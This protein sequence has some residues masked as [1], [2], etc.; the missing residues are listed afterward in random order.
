[1]VD[2]YRIAFGKVIQLFL[3]YSKEYLPFGSS[4]YIGLAY[5]MC[6]GVVLYRLQHACKF[7]LIEQ[8]PGS[9]PSPDGPFRRQR[10]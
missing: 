3:S 8:V 10:S 9:P 1:M 4:L 5:T 6:V 7:G 2:F